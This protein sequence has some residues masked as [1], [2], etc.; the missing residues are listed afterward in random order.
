MNTSV[1]ITTIICFT[2]IMV[3]WITKDSNKG[4]KT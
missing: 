2:I 1:I 3:C 4:K